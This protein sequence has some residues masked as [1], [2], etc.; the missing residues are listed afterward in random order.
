MIRILTA[1]VVAAMLTGVP[2]GAF[3]QNG[4]GNDEAALIAKAEKIH[5]DVITLDTHDDINAANFTEAVNYTQDLNTQVNL[6]KM[7]KGGLDVA[8]FIVYTGQ[9]DLAKVRDNLKA[10]GLEVIAAELSY[11]PNT[12]L[13]ISD[14]AVQGKIERLMD[15][16]DELDDVT[17]TYT[18]FDIV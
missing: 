16:L 1:A 6:P 11:E 5:K 9:G 10:A 2:G 18:N 14:E 17:N 4:N 3:A 7:R 13:E 8:W 15:A 12:T